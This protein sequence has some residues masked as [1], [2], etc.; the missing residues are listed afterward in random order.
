M[1]IIVSNSSNPSRVYVRLCKH[2]ERFLLLIQTAK[3]FF[4]A[5]N[6]VISVYRRD[7]F[8][9]LLWHC[10]LFCFVLFFLLV[11]VKTYTKTLRRTYSG[12]FLNLALLPL[13]WCLS[14]KKKTSVSC[15]KKCPNII[16][17]AP[18]PTVAQL[19]KITPCPIAG[20][21]KEN[22]HFHTKRS[23]FVGGIYTKAA[24]Y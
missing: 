24:S 23:A 9:F 14:G 22:M 3:S 8:A 2:G 21:K 4:S 1:N 6:L 10:F 7:D 16:V 15:S 20:Q 5:K 19:G 13:H 11:D 18:R 17:S 12:V